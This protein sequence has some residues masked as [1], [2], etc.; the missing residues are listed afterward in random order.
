MSHGVLPFK[1][2]MGTCGQPGYV[3]RDDFCLRQGIECFQFLCYL[4]LDDKQPARMFY[5]LMMYNILVL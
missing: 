1:G 2:L 3:F 4:F 5:E